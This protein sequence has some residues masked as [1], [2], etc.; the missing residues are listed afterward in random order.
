MLGR[1]EGGVVRLT[2]LTKIKGGAVHARE[3]IALDWRR[4]AIAIEVGVVLF[5]LGDWHGVRIGSYLGRI[6]HTRLLHVKLCEGG[7]GDSLGFVPGR[8]IPVKRL[9]TAVDHVIGSRMIVSTAHHP[10]AT[11]NLGDL[12]EK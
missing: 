8:S 2:L 6:G 12:R 4:A 7:L 9:T 5:S 11:I 3:T 10:T 1:V